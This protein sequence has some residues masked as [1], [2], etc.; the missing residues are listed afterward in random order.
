MARKYWQRGFGTAAS[1]KLLE[2]LSQVKRNAHEAL[3]RYMKQRRY[4]L[5]V[6]LEGYPQ[7]R[8]WRADWLRQCLIYGP[9]W[10][11]DALRQ[12]A[13]EEIAGADAY[14]VV[15]GLRDVL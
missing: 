9:K 8:L 11:M 13:R 3:E 10:H 12:R 15:S 5:F 6:D 7:Y 14:S 4:T 1:P 2:A